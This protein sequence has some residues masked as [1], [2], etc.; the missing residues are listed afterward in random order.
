MSV[1]LGMWN[2]ECGLFCVGWTFLE[3]GHGE[4]C[5]ERHV[6]RYVEEG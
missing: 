1:C 5:V 6:R 4:F 3:G 2:R